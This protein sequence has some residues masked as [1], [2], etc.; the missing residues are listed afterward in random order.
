MA[1][2]GNGLSCVM[3]DMTGEGSFSH[4][5]N[6]EKIYL[7]YEPSGD[8]MEDHFIVSQ[9]CD[10]EC[11]TRERSHL[12]A[13]CAD[14][15]SKG[16]L[17]A[18]ALN[19]LTPASGLLL[20]LKCGKTFETKCRHYL[21]HSG[22]TPFTCP[23]CG[24]K[25]KQKSQLLGHQKV[26]TGEKPFSCQECEERFIWRR[27]SL[28]TTVESVFRAEKSWLCTRSFTLEMDCGKWFTG[29][30]QLRTHRGVH[31]G[32]KPFACA[33]CVKAFK[34]LPPLQRLHTVE[35]PFECKECRKR[36]IT[37]AELSHQNVHSGLKP[38]S[39]EEC[40][41]CFTLKG[42]LNAHVRSFHVDLKPFP[43][44]ECGK[45]F[46]HQS[47]LAT[48]QRVH[49]REK[50]VPCSECGR[51]FLHQSYLAS[52]MR[53]HS[54]ERPFSCAGCGKS[55]T[56]KVYLK[57]HQKMHTTESND[58]KMHTSNPDVH[59]ADADDQKTHAPESSF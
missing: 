59:V 55:F 56:L 48:H 32:E 43:C 52:H 9:D 51:S 20:A 58:Q 44:L 2:P 17:T 19:R 10:Q 7:L 57:K 8:N 3:Q 53:V 34:Q 36:F 11:F 22:E 45:C 23:E 4:T 50:S 24:K 12:P 39:C 31:T 15:A 1:S 27:G 29:Q 14:D 54:Q 18:I 41:E 42:Q 13:Q 33:E 35:R 26:H 28:N 40:G 49:T 47:H 6:N 5:P 21:S 30:S 46:I 38:F 37:K 25:Y 16:K